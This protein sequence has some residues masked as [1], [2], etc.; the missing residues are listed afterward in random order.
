[1]AWS[2]TEFDQT[3]VGSIVLWEV[4]IN[5]ID[6]PTSLTFLFEENMLK[7]LQRRHY[8]ARY[9]DFMTCYGQTD[10][11]CIC[12]LRPTFPY[13]PTYGQDTRSINL[14]YDNSR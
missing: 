12:I 11:H 1:M 7:E 9:L 5:R 4:D 8:E 10:I 14:Q 2:L 3:L 6:D 13:W